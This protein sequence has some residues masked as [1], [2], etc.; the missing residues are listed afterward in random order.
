[1]ITDRY[2]FGSERRELPRHDIVRSRCSLAS[3]C[4]GPSKISDYVLTTHDGA[5]WADS[6]GVVNVRNNMWRDADYN[7]HYDAVMEY[8]RHHSVMRNWAYVARGGRVLVDGDGNFSFGGSPATNLE[9]MIVKGAFFQEAE[10]SYLSRPN[11]EPVDHLGLRLENLPELLRSEI[12]Q[13]LETEER[14]VIGHVLDVRDWTRGRVEDVEEGVIPRDEFIFPSDPFS[15]DCLHSLAMPCPPVL[16]RRLHFIARYLFGNGVG[17]GTCIDHLGPGGHFLIGDHVTLIKYVNSRPV[18]MDVG[19]VIQRKANCCCVLMGNPWGNAWG[20]ALEG[21]AFDRVSIDTWMAKHTGTL[22]R[23]PKFKNLR[24]VGLDFTIT[25]VPHIDENPV[26]RNDENPQLEE[27]DEAED[28]VYEG[29]DDS[30]DEE[31][32][33]EDDEEEG[34]EDEY[35]GSTG[36]VDSD[37]HRYSDSDFYD[38]EGNWR[39]DDWSWEGE[40]NNYGD[41]VRPSDGDEVDDE[42]DYLLHGEENNYGDHYRPF[43]ELIDGDEVDDEEEEG[44]DGE[45]GDEGWDSENEADVEDNDSDDSDWF[46]EFEGTLNIPGWTRSVHARGME[47]YTLDDSSSS[48]GN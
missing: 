27:D 10:R 22:L 7:R 31:E 13:F 6:W 32:G 19:F 12:L 15:M 3:G 36:L 40:E 38:S 18:I 26:P 45:V 2:T 33:D 43:E 35:D 47:M 30:D 42:Y 14:I 23:F 5:L 16:L 29:S 20:N 8:S 28:T 44:D 4:Q 17:P 24:H 37:G 1:M 48:D 39:V 41:H 21:F 9:R 34:A 46:P 25:P 11:P